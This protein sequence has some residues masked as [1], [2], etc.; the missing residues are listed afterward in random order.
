MAL[1]LVLG[2]EA[3]GE[4]IRAHRDRQL[5]PGKKRHGNEQLLGTVELLGSVAALGAALDRSRQLREMKHVIL[6]LRP[7]VSVTREGARHGLGAGHPEIVH[8]VAMSRMGE[9]RVNQISREVG[10]VARGSIEVIY[11]GRVVE[12]FDQGPILFNRRRNNQDVQSALGRGADHLPPFRLSACLTGMAGTIVT[13]NLLAVVFFECVLNLPRRKQRAALRIGH[14]IHENAQRHDVPFE[15]LVFAQSRVIAHHGTL[16][17]RP[18]QAQLYRRGRADAR[19]VHGAMSG[20]CDSRD[21]C[22]ERFV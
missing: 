20:P 14:A 1:K 12:F 7:R 10:A 2:I 6:G 17:V 11:V 22:V 3:A 18:A 13:E 21:A 19:Q 16:L 15:W 4:H 5:V 8:D 9:V